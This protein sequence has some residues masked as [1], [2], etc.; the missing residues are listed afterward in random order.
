MIAPNYLQFANLDAQKTKNTHNVK[1]VTQPNFKGHIETPVKKDVWDVYSV[2][3]A[4]VYFHNT[5][6]AANEY[7]RANNLPT[8]GSVTADLGLAYFYGQT[9]KDALTGINNRAALDKDI[10]SIAQKMHK[11][12]KSL[13]IIMG[14]LDNFKAVNTFLGYREGDE[15]IKQIGNITNKIAHDNGAITYRLGGD[16]FMT[17]V[18]GKSAEESRLIAEKI[19]SGLRGNEYMKSKLDIFRANGSLEAERL[20]EAQAVFNGL[21]KMANDL[22]SLGSKVDQ[23]EKL[24][25]GGTKI[26]QLALREAKKKHIDDKQAFTQELKTAFSNFIDA[27]DKKISDPDREMLSKRIADLDRGIDPVS[28]FREQHMTE[29]LQ[30]QLNNSVKIAQY[31]KWVG[32][33]KDGFTATF[34][35]REYSGQELL[36]IDKTENV[37]RELD[38]LLQ[39]GKLSGKN[40]VFVAETEGRVA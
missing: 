15:F 25:Q 12:G 31:E 33:S 35:V 21:S 14:D 6:E 17:L 38:N 5:R 30:T 4:K 9:R 18:P 26:D 20:K 36:S 2:K 27:E 40:T 29:F 32:D 39:V 7:C 1:N 37:V 13:S 16:E 8:S 11:E 22:T 24:K 23:L 34:G 10:K 19:L 28:I 3:E